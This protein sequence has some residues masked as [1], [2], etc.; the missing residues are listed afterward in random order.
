MKLSAAEHEANLNLLREVFPALR[1]TR[2]R[3]SAPSYNG[4]GGPG[5]WRVGA[6]RNEGHGWAVTVELGGSDKYGSDT[7]FG[8]W[9]DSKRPDDLRGVAVEARCWMLAM[10]ETAARMFE[11]P[12][13][14]QAAQDAA[15]PP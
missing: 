5:R 8:T 2:A 15:L 6:W 9:R 7:E 1:W 13:P 11:A 10:A 14:T 3:E 4:R 12:R